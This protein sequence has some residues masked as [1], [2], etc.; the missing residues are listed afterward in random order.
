VSTE[1]ALRTTRLGVVLRSFTERVDDVLGAAREAEALGLHGVFVYDH[2]WPLGHRGAPALGAFP[3]LGAIAAET[4]RV[5][6]GPLVA[7]IGLVEDARLVQQFATLET[8]SNG[9][10]IAALGT[11]D[12]KSSPENLAYGIGYPS[13]ASRRASLI[14]VATSL[15]E[16]DIATWIGG[17]SPG[18]SALARDLKVAQ[19]LWQVEPQV[20][21][22]VA[23]VTSA[24]WAGLL[25]KDRARATRELGEL[26]EAGASWVIYDWPGALEPILEVAS[27]AGVTLADQPAST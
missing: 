16:R 18:I 7:R 9:R 15:V 20:I 19:N 1:P 10:L 26:V 11:G 8:L 5:A 4:S 3:L 22:S 25:P 6:L 23:R 27:G 17:V 12:K 21:E 2:L 13:A 14:E 24:T